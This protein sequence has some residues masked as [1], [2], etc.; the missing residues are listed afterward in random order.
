VTGATAV[1]IAVNAM[2]Q[3]RQ[4]DEAIRKSKEQKHTTIILPV[5]EIQTTTQTPAVHSE[6]EDIMKQ[7]YKDYV[8]III[9][10]VIALYLITKLVSWIPK[11]KSS[12][13][14]KKH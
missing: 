5:T 4:L 6:T 2:Q 13:K 9:V 12:W 7:V 11:I 1:F 3:Q 8:I 10:F 14:K